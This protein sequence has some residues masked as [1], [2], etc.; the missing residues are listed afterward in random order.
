MAKKGKG[1]TEG[2]GTERG[3]EEE[4]KEKVKV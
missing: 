1:G 2:K 4:R 3:Q